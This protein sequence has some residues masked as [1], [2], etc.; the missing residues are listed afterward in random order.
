MTAAI[1]EHNRELLESTTKVL[2]DR[3][4]LEGESLRTILSQV[5]APTG[6]AD[7]LLGREL[8]RT[9]DPH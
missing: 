1:L 2:L 5:K 3:Q 9:V 6:L 4:V 7:W 8:G